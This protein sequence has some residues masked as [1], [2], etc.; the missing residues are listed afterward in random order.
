MFPSNE[1]RFEEPALA[2]GFSLW[3]DIHA[4]AELVF[5]F[6]TDASGL[7]RWW[8][9]HCE[10]EARPGGHLHCRWDGQHP[11]TGDAI[12]RHFDPPTHLL[13]EWTHN[14]GQPI[15]SDG[16]DPR[17]M[18]WPAL[19]QFDLRLIDSETT[20]LQLHDLGINPSPEY[21]N[22][23]K[24]TADGWQRSLLSLKKAVEYYYQQQLAKL[25]K[26]KRLKRSKDQKRSFGPDL[27]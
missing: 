10:S 22:I 18:R 21:A 27:S 25:E 6:L 11:V 24:A 20:R 14:N 8:A 2:V 26:K 12:F 17:G 23:R 9:T 3:I 16:N 19:N 5:Y 13:L 7:N 15:H 4:P 1:H